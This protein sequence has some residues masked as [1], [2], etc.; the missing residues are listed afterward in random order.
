MAGRFQRVGAVFAKFDTATSWFTPELLTMPAGDDARS[1]IDDT[2]A[3]APYR[4]TILDNYRQQTHVLD[5]QGERLL[6]LAGRFNQTPRAAYQE[7]STSDIKFPTITLSDGKEVTLTPGNYGA[8]LESNPNQA[9]RAKAAAAHVGTYGATANTYAAIYNAHC[10][11]A[12]GSW[13]RRATS[14]RTLDAALDGN[15]IPRAGGRD[16]G[17]DHARRHRAAAALRCGCASGCSG[18]TSYH[19]YDG[20]VPVFRSDKTYPYEHGAR[21]GAG[22]GGAA[23]RRLRGQVPPVRLAAGASTS[24]RTRASAAAP[25]APASTASAPTC[26]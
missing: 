4:F 5:E 23:G 17:R 19:L 14:R 22:R 15:A 13:P 2:P 18:W 25:T 7:L 11:S 21:A 26:C 8:L 3:L 12:T 6:S 1:W 24:T 20:F 16:P 9:D 10:C